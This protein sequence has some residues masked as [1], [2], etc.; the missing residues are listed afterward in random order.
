MFFSI[1]LLD[2]FF[3]P[4]PSGKYSNLTS[5]TSPGLFPESSV[6]K[7]SYFSDSLDYIKIILAVSLS[8]LYWGSIALI[9]S[10]RLLILTVSVNW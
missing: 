7:Y 4:W 8:K 2:L 9:L 1:F 3:K 6:V 10:W 5:S